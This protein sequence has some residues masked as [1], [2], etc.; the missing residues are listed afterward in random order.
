M[1]T[2]E[3]IRYGKY[4]IACY[5]KNGELMCYYWD[6]MNWGLAKVNDPKNNHITFTRMSIK[7]AKDTMEEIYKELYQD[8]KLFLIPMNDAKKW[9][10]TKE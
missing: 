6:S 4:Y 10:I 2:D 3:S 5:T 8:L 9:N 1:A 7:V